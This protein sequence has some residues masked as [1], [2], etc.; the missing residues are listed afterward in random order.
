MDIKSTLKSKPCFKA[1]SSAN[2]ET[3]IQLE[4]KLSLKFA[5]EYVEYLKSFGFVTYEGHE[6]TGI[7]KVK[8]LNVVDVTTEEKESNDNVPND[9]YVIEQLN[10]DDIVIWQSSSGEIYQTAPAREPVKLCDSLTEYI[11]RY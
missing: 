7:C 5:Q 8:R 6:L 11:E 1:Y 4:E 10:I 9:W 3:I 2:N